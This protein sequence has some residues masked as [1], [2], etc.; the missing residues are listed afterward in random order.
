MLNETLLD[1]F[2][3]KPV[4]NVCAV[5][6]TNRV[7]NPSVMTGLLQQFLRLIVPLIYVSLGQKQR[8][9]VCCCVYNMQC[10]FGK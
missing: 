7:P 8:M 5:E 9:R 4:E 1:G 2:L 6:Q 10:F 3:Y